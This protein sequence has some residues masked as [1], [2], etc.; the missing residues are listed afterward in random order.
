MRTSCSILALLSVCGVGVVMGDSLGHDLV[1]RQPA[2][3]LV[4]LA[5]RLK[6]T[7]LVKALKDTG[8]ARLLNH[9]GQTMR[10]TCTAA[11]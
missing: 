8:L 9:E 5:E 1:D 11:L 7:T 6:L 2:P 10:Q 4:Q 3:N